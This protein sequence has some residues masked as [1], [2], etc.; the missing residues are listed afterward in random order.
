MEVFKKSV[1]GFFVFSLIWMMGYSM[2]GQLRVNDCPA[3]L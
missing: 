2:L 3:G 1:A